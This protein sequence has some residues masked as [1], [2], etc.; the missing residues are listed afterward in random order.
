MKK[1]AALILVFSF[2][3]Y[4]VYPIAKAEFSVSAKAAIVIAADTLEVLYEKSANQ[5]LPMASTT[6]IMTALLLAEQPDLSKTVK[7]T[8]QMVTVEGS[9]MG[10]LEGDT[11]SY[12]DLL[13]GMLLA[14]GNDAAN[15]TAYVLAGSV[16]GFAKMM[17]EKAAELGMKNTSFVTPSG[18]DDENHYTTAYDLALLTAAALKNSAFRTACS[19]KSAVLYYGNPPYRRTLTN[20]NKLL[21]NYEG[22]IGVKTGFTKKSGRCLVTAAEGEGKRV[23]AVTLN[24]PDDWNDHRKLLDYGLEKTVVTEFKNYDVT[25][26]MP[27]VC[28]SADLV[29]VK[30]EQ[31]KICTAVGTENEIKRKIILPK[32]IYAPI[33]AGEKVGEI[34]YYFKDTLVKT[35]DIFSV[36]DVESYNRK[37]NFQKRFL[38]NLKVLWNN[39]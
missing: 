7:T 4:L 28:G 23:I 31:A 36:A 10:L 27:I 39:I 19:S 35:S 3:L 29:R 5:K 32:F 17:N 33:S 34:E 21:G 22:I 14:S 24:D 8:K 1:S 20:H 18:L 38:N 26:V 30:C 12:R 16:Q 11:V 2:L 15:T 37:E 25:D 6:K 9:S 13:Y